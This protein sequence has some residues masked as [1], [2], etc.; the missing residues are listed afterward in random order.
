MDARQKQT[1]RMVRS[2]WQLSGFLGLVGLGLVAIAY[3]QRAYGPEA[4]AQPP[5]ESPPTT[6]QQEIPADPTNIRPEVEPPT[7]LVFESDPLPLSDDRYQDR[8][9]SYQETTPPTETVVPGQGLAPPPSLMRAGDTLPPAERALPPPV[10]LPPPNFGDRELPPPVTSTVVVEEASNAETPTELPPARPEATMPI[11]PPVSEERYQAPVPRYGNDEPA[12]LE[13]DPY[14]NA[15]APP[16]E[17]SPAT[18][19]PVRQVPLERQPYREAASEPQRNTPVAENRPASYVRQQDAIEPQRNPLMVGT[20]T[21]GEK[22]LEGAQSAQVVLERR[23]PAQM[24]VGQAATI[25][26]VVRNQ[27]LV[28]AQQVVVSDVIPR[29]ARLIETT[30]APT[31]QEAA[32][33]YWRLGT[34][35]PKAE[36]II[37]LQLMPLA[38][39]EIGSVASVT[40]TTEATSRTLV[41][42]PRLKLQV[43]AAPEVLID[44]EIILKITVANEGTG[45][46]RQ[47]KLRETI[48]K[49]LRHPAGDELEY[50]VGDLEPGKSQ[51][52]Q[53][54]LRAVQPGITTN[55][56]Q[57]FAEG[58]VESE[59]NKTQI[60]IVSPALKV[61]ADGPSR[62]FLERE[63]VYT[64]SVSNPGTAPANQVA[65]KT[66]LPAGMKFVKTDSSGRYDAATRTVHW[67]LDELPAQRTGNVKLTLLPID[68][69]DH[70]LQISAAA[71]RGLQ[72][73]A[74]QTTSVEGVAAVLFQV[75]D[76][77]DPVEIGGETVYEIRL[78]NQGSKASSNL[79]VVAELSPAF[80][81]LGAEG[82][83]EFDVQGN[84]VLFQPIAKLAPKANTTIRVRVQGIQ[85]GDGR[86][87][88]QLMTDE[89]SRPVTKEEST[90]IYSDE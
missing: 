67:L 78:V 35:G 25:E 8:Y 45:T 37:R 42:Q 33:L 9:T 90:R 17:P 6:V 71:N 36:S 76:L 20:A 18:T 38:E 88:V 80:K 53:L 24:Q 28:T 30:P 51:E 89:M 47:V 46:A 44:E 39:G 5:A 27:G 66:V 49:E 55:L 57:I 83:T 21:P 54:A 70:A 87:R 84:Q 64:I 75:V 10:E 85:S 1:K 16:A 59:V 69:G 32:K 4:A 12:E 63:A 40:C 56:M 60:A 31:E 34:L 81:F 22:S 23:A 72:A 14:E 58:N 11:S 15:A 82:E 43:F 48:P 19:M 61:V 65:L 7:K 73:Q 29:G 13:V 86:F 26:L 77:E 2:L 62:R 41:T 79:R 50:L 3:A 68:V 52:L 74:Q